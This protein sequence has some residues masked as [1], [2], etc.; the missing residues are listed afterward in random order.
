MILA[1]FSVKFGGNLRQETRG[2]LYGFRHG[3]DDGAW[4]MTEPV[5]SLSP[6]PL[7][8]DCHSTHIKLKGPGS[9]TELCYM[10]HQLI[11]D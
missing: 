2:I 8:R 4:D 6:E 5:L 3:Q 9:S 10:H 7:G 11:L 1:L